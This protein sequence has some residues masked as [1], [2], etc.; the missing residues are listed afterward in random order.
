MNDLFRQAKKQPFIAIPAGFDFVLLFC[1]FSPSAGAYPNNRP[2]PDSASLH[3]FSA[4]RFSQLDTQPASSVA[5]TDRHRHIN[6]A[7]P[8]RY[9]GCVSRV[10]N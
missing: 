1:L 8:Y 3:Y 9:S 10:S 5:H 2:Q 7:P 6:S 4:Y